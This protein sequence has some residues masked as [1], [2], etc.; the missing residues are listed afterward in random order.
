[1]LTSKETQW[2]QRKIN[3][4]AGFATLRMYDHALAALAEVPPAYEPFL[5]HVLRGELHRDFAHF[6]LALTEFD[7][8]GELEPANI[9]VMLA[10][11]WCYK[12]TD[13]LNQAIALTRQAL[14]V[15]PGDVIVNY[16]LACY[17]CLAGRR[18]DCL[19]FLRVALELR[20]EMAH[21]I[22][23][24]RDFDNLRTDPEFQL[25]QETFRLKAD[26]SESSEKQVE[27]GEPGA[28]GEPGEPHLPPPPPPKPRKKRGKSGPGGVSDSASES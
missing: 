26:R 27:P 14:L 5:L 24:E 13:R 28:P 12:R 11:A 25:L 22:P 4:S 20:P 23:R 19:K 10:K 3:E 15:E 6:E 9:H 17:S 7:R 1:V 2:A 18:A 16:N 21:S 8:A